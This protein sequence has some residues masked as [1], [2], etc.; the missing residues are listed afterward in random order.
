M[1]ALRRIL[2]PKAVKLY[3]IGVFLFELSPFSPYLSVK[4]I[5]ANMPPLYDLKALLVFH[6][7][8]FMNTQFIVQISLIAVGAVL[9]TYAYSLVR[10]MADKSA[11]S[12]LAG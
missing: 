5:F 8:A 3:I 4:N 12:G 11:H 6:T 7:V 2:S 10:N 1:Y 9:M